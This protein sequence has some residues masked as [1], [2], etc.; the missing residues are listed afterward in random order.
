VAHV[1]DLDFFVETAIVD[2]LNMPAAEREKMGDAVP[3]QSLGDEAPSV[4]ESHARNL[5]RK[6]DAVLLG[7]EVGLVQESEQKIGLLWPTPPAWLD[8]VRSDFDA[9]LQDHAACERKASATAVTLALHYRDREKLVSAMVELA[10][11]ELEHFRK[12][13]RYIA[14]RNVTLGVDHKDVYVRRLMALARKGTDPY[15]LDR[16][17]IA[18]I[19]EARGSERFGLLAKGLGSDAADLYSELARSEARHAGLFVGLAKLYFDRATVEHRLRELFA[20][21]AK[22]IAELP[23]RPALH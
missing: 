16:L 14:A 1:D 3:V 19:I 23:L 2:G 8:V 20:A 18:G 21:E 5:T 4:Y 10:C 15:F 11:E 17:L 22:I 6:V 9:F 12:V 13:Y 7:K